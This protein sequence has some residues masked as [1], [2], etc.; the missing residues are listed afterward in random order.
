M[1]TYALFQGHRLT[2][3][4]KSHKQ[5]NSEIKTKKNCKMKMREEHNVE[6]NLIAINISLS[7]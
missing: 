1:S 3:P 6:K 4:R 2:N 5:Q 7:M